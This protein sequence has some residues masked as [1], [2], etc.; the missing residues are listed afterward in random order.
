[1]SQ[2]L[3]LALAVLAGLACPLHM[4]W[5]HRRGRQRACG[6]TRN[7]DVDG[8]LEGLRARQQHLGVLIA[9]HDPGAPEQPQSAHTL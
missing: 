4:W 9:E 7:L 8:R 6:P 1:M 5:S 2:G 3:V